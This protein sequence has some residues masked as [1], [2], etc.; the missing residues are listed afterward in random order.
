[1]DSNTSSIVTF[2]IAASSECL[3]RKSE[4]ERANT[5]QDGASYAAPSFFCRTWSRAQASPKRWAPNTRTSPVIGACKAP[6]I[7][8]SSTSRG[9]TA[10][11]SAISADPTTR[12]STTP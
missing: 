8:A 6:A 2:A 7:R 1:M 9:G 5:S 4:T 10:A 11:S 12:P 3:V